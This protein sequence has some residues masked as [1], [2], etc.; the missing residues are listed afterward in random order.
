[1]D[2]KPEAAVNASRAIYWCYRGGSGDNRNQLSLMFP[3]VF[4]EQG[5]VVG[6]AE[7][8]RFLPTCALHETSTEDTL[9]YVNSDTLTLRV[10]GWTGSGRQAPF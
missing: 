10:G 8:L 4:A 5:S 1:V 9:W 2:S 7:A 6:W 3:R